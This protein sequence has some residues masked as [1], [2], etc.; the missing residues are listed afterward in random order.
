MQNN[1]IYSCYKHKVKNLIFLGSS[2]I[3][4]NNITV[5]IK[6]DDLLKALDLLRVSYKDCI[7]KYGLVK[8]WDLSEME[9]YTFID[10]FDYGYNC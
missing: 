6:E 1:L 2:C 7:E 8:D 4:P 10:F 5:P 3:Y 9:P